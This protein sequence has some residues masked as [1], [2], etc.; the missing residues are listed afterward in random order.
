MYGYIYIYTMNIHVYTYV[1]VTVDVNVD[2]NAHTCI[3]VYLCM[4]MYVCTYIYIC[5]TLQSLSRASKVYCLNGHLSR[6]KE[7]GLMAPSVCPA[8]TKSTCQLETPRVMK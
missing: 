8:K 3:H 6:R 2:L 4:Y 1:N 7:S 5:I